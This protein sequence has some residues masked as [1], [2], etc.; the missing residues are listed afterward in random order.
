MICFAN[1][2]NHLPAQ[3]IESWSRVYSLCL[4]RKRCTVRIHRQIATEPRPFCMVLPIY[5]TPR[6]I[7]PG[8]GDFK[9]F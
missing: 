6:K 2:D 7:F 3:S 4:S 1:N 8:I 5:G 9:T